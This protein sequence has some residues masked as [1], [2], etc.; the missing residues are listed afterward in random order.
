MESGSY[1]GIKLLEHAMKVVERI[2]KHRIWQ[3]LEVD[4][5]QFVFIKSKR[6]TDAIFTV[7]QTHK[8]FRVK[9]KKLYFGFVDLEKTFDRVPREVIRW[10]MHK[11]GVEE[12]LVSAVVSMYA[13]AK[14]VV[15]G[16]YGN[17]SC[18]KVKVGIHQGSHKGSA[19][20]PLLFVIVMEAISREF[21]VP[22]LGSCCMLMTWLW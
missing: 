18:S 17:S 4:D 21:R 10:A 19:L 7:R 2:F 9:E 12:W 15:R 11:L 14:T 3:Q 22:Y 6:T 13:G 8:N 16:V 20:S 1:R 5:I